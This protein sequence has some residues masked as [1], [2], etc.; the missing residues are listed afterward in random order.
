MDRNYERILNNSSYGELKFGGAVFA[1][2]SIR[3]T[4]KG[5]IE[6]LK[7][8]AWRARISHKGAEYKETFWLKSEAIAWLKTKS[9]EFNPLKY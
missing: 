2:E 9:H 1:D 7:S 4:Y 3:K 5:S 8:G 6:Q